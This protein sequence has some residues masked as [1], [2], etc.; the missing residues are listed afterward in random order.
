MLARNGRAPIGE[1]R[2]YVDTK[3][4]DFATPLAQAQLGAALAMMGDKAARREGLAGGAQGSTA[5]D[6]CVTRRDYGT[7]CATARR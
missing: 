7:A 2:Y 4:D 6:D 5:K 1:L 3:L